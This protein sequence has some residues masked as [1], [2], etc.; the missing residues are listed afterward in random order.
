MCSYCGCVANTVI[1][2]LML[3][4]EEIVNA[5]GAV[6]RAVEGVP[7][8]SVVETAAALQALLTP[9]T[10]SE[11]RGLFAQM[12]PDPEFRDHIEGLSVEHREIDE[13]LARVAAGEHGVFH[14][15]E[16]LLRNHMDKE[17]NGLFPAAIIALDGEAWERVVNAA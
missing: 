14:D 6:R 11:E 10:E 8:Y 16:R 5:L 9:H 13:R 2:Q 4:H 1:A 3:E 15:F 17:D 7:G 12:L